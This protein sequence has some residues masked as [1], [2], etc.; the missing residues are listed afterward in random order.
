VLTGPD[1]YDATTRAAETARSDMSGVRIGVPREW[2]EFPLTE[3]VRAALT[4]AI[5]TLE[6]SGVEVQ[7]VRLPS[8]AHMVSTYYVLA[9]AEASSNMGRFDGIRF[10]TRADGASLRDVYVNSRS[11]GFGA[12]V[13]RRILLGTFVLSSGY[14]DAYY[15]RAARARMHIAR[16]MT[17]T[18]KQVTAL[19]G[20]TT[21]GPAPKL[22]TQQ[23]PIDAYRGDVLTLPANLSGRPAL[24]IPQAHP[25]A[26]PVGVQ[27]VGNPD[28]E[29]VLLALGER[30]ASP[31]RAPAC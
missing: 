25:S 28:A 31:W 24:A 20:P 1:G 8:T 27:L 4:D 7:E 26:L 30:L 15:E 3:P 13:Q 11:N 17:E 22:G 10:G 12:E 2:M 6:A 29:H 14:Y 21:L 23:S 19:L 18:F 9:C 16:E 5:R